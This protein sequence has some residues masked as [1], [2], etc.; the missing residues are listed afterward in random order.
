MALNT[1]SVSSPPPGVPVTGTAPAGERFGATGGGDRG[2]VAGVKG[3]SRSLVPARLH[4][5]RPRAVLRREGRGAPSALGAVDFG[6]GQQATLQAVTD[7]A[8]PENKAFWEATPNGKLEI[9]ISNPV[10]RDFFKPG[11]AYYRGMTIPV[12][13]EG[14]SLIRA[15]DLRTERIRRLQEALCECQHRDFFQ[16]DLHDETCP[17]YVIAE[18]QKREYEPRA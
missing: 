3:G 12:S 4:D 15:L 14:V 2:A 16:A 1:E 11:K 9:S 10:L 6:S 18:E 13:E 7:T 5:R 17:V 8:D